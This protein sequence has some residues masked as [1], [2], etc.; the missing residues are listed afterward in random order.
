MEVRFIFAS[1]ASKG[2]L[3]RYSHLKVKCKKKEKIIRKKMWIQT[4]GD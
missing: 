4:A 3:M 1:Y 2:N